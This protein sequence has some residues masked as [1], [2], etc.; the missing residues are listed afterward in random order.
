MTVG[1]LSS[2]TLVASRD[3]VCKK[4]FLFLITSG[5][6]Y[7][8]NFSI[9]LCNLQRV[10][11][12]GFL[13]IVSRGCWSEWT[14]MSCLPC[15]SSD[16]IYPCRIQSQDTVSRLEHS[17]FLCWWG[18]VKWNGQ[19]AP[20]VVKPHLLHCQMRLLEVSLGGVGHNSAARLLRRRDV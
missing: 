4:L 18:Y 7:F 15:I 13:K 8:C 5:N 3:S 1:V 10:L 9:I 17:F 14:L 20:L 11:L 19:G 6:R 12:K 2:W 16:A